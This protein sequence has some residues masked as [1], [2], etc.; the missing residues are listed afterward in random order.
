MPRWGLS[1]RGFDRF[2]D[3]IAMPRT[4][5]GKLQTSLADIL[6]PAALIRNNALSGPITAGSN[7]ATSDGVNQNRARSA[8]ERRPRSCHPPFEGRNLI[9]S[10]VLSTDVM[11]RAGLISRNSR[12]PLRAD[13][14][15]DRRCQFNQTVAHFAV[16][17]TGE[18]WTRV[19]HRL[20]PVARPSHS[21]TSPSDHRPTFPNNLDGTVNQIGPRKHRGGW[22]KTHK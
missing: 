5:T 10:S 13:P 16:G 7:P 20:R 21:S 17:I 14:F 11:H 9:T 1:A 6:E 2:S 18:S 19:I 15:S 12:H 3:N 22:Q 8:A 4:K